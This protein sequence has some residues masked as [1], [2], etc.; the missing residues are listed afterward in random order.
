MSQVSMQNASVET[1]SQ[2]QQKVTTYPITTLKPL[3]I[4]A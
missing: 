3:V 1:F 2:T 4:T